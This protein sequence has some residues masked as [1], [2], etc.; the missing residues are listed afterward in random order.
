ME[1][2]GNWIILLIVVLLVGGA[3]FAYNQRNKDKEFS[4][5]DFIE[6]EQT[7]LMENDKTMEENK[8]TD[9]TG[10]QPS[11]ST[12]AE[13]LNAPTA[14]ADAT[15]LKSFTITASNFKFS[16]SE[17]RVKKGDPVE[18]T[19]VNQSGFHDL[20]IDGYNTRTKQLRA[21]EKEVTGFIASKT[22][23]FEIYCSVG[24]HRSMG[25]VGTLIVE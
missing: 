7:E 20:V 1:N 11:A 8:S 3:V 23:I 4:Q 9:Q 25:M 16:P 17:I 2:R 6:T 18:I 19:F 13:T 24:N 21:G 10:A 15:Q 5:E 14:G 22:G 12:E